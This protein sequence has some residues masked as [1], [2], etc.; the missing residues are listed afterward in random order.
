MI[1]AGDIPAG[2]GQKE[3]QFVTVAFQGEIWFEEAGL[4]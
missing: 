4:A 1:S 2:I 3:L